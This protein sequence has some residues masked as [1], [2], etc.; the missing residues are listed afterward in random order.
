MGRERFYVL[1]IEIAVL[2]SIVIITE[3][4]MSNSQ[5]SR[6]PWDV[7]AARGLYNIDRWGA[8]YFDINDAGHVVATPLQE[9]GASVDLTDDSDGSH[10]G[11][12]PARAQQPDLRGDRRQHQDPRA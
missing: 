7:N 12:E 1:H 5:E 8:K 11:L 6:Q 4:L 10:Q 2:G 9:A 3:R